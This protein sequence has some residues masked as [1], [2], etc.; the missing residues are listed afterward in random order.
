M[1]DAKDAFPVPEPDRFGNYW[2]DDQDGP[3][4]FPIRG[5]KG[6]V[7]GWMAS[8]GTRRGAVM[9]ATGIKAFPTAAEAI[10]AVIDRRRGR[11]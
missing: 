4:V 1:D 11:R 2:F 3:A 10:Q 5:I 7:G 9:D 8:L 6:K